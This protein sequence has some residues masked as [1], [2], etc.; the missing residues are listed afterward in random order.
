V[1]QRGLTKTGDKIMTFAEQLRFEEYQK[2]IA[3]AEQLI[4]AGYQRGI[5]ETMELA[6]RLKTENKIEIATKLLQQ[7]LDANLVANSTGLP[8]AQILELEKNVKKT[9]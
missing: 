9:A 8:L 5:A 2:G 1:I 3:D 4:S 6:E 7:N